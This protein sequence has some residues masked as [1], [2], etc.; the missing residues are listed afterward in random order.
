M[1]ITEYR[2]LLLFLLLV[3]GAGL[4]T[5]YGAIKIIPIVILL[6]MYYKWVYPSFKIAS[7]GNCWLMAYMTFNVFL[8]LRCCFYDSNEGALGNWL[9]SLIGNIAVGLPVLLMPMLM[10]ITFKDNFL[11]NFLKVC[12]ILIYLNMVVSCL[13]ILGIALPYANAFLM[14]SVF[15]SIPY[16]LRI[17]RK[18]IWLAVILVLYRDM[19]DGER[20]MFISLILTF[21]LTVVLTK[22]PGFKNIYIIACLYGMVG[23]TI[24]LLFFNLY[25][26]E[27]FFSWLTTSY[28]DNEVVGDNTRSFLFFEIIEDFNKNSAWVWGKGIFGTYFSQVMFDAKS[29]GDYVDN[30]NRLIT[31]C[32]WLLLLLKGGL[33][34]VCLYASTQ[35]YSMICA[36]KKKN[37][38]LNVC[39]IILSVHF[40]MMFVSNS[41]YFDL[42]NVL[43]WIVAGMCLT[44]KI[45]IQ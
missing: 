19:I 18:L 7:K 13:C 22:I 8:I 28:G 38:L 44:N 37:G 14:T 12:K 23:I 3:V 1:K 21:G 2:K 36:I 29:R 20:S 30:M 26:Q 16:Y 41:I 5:L 4:L 11:S 32:G 31:E 35:I 27:D 43:Y 42:P 40:M 6:Y 10:G 15:L 25:V 33:V 17:D 45:N 9:L 39:V 24:F 34:N